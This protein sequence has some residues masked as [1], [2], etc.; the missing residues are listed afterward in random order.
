MSHT[1]KFGTMTSM[2]EPKKEKKKVYASFKRPKYPEEFSL[3]ECAAFQPWHVVLKVELDA[4]DPEPVDYELFLRAKDPADAQW[5]AHDV[6]MIWE[7]VNKNDYNAYPQVSTLVPS[8][9][10]PITEDDWNDA[11][12]SAQRTTHLKAGMEENPT[13]FRIIKPDWDKR[14]G[15]LSGEGRSIILPDTQSIQFVESTRNRS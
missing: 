15:I 9:A 11:W 6:F 5:T 13:I 14:S 12:K 8:S 7:K 3:K 10:E 2:S 4:N 1:Q